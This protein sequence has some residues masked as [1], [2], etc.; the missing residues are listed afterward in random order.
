MAKR[1]LKYFGKKKKKSYV[2]PAGP[3]G[4]RNGKALSIW[5]EDV[6]TQVGKY[7]C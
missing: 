4:R 2:L 3:G 1:F 7:K 5:K 6:K